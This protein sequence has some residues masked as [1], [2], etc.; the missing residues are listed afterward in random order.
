VK[1]KVAVVT[2]AEAEVAARV[3]DLPG[4]IKDGLMAFASATG[5]VVIYQMMEAE[6]E[7][8]IGPKH[9]RIP[10]AERVGNW[11]G[12]TEGPAPRR[13]PRFSPAGRSVSPRQLNVTVAALARVEPD[14]TAGS[15][16]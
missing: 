6:L 11:H 7:G 1:K 10:A 5:L 14:P 3:A 15:R 12:S 13:D 2:V 4:A 8:R 9:A 16:L